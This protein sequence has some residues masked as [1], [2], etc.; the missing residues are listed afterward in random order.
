MDALRSFILRAISPRVCVRDV[1]MVRYASVAV[2]RA[3]A[4][5][6][7]SCVRV[8]SLCHPGQ[9]ADVVRAL[10]GPFDTDEV[11]SCL[12]L[13]HLPMAGA[14]ATRVC[15]H[16]PRYST[17]VTALSLLPCQ[18]GAYATWCGFSTT[19]SMAARS[20]THGPST[21]SSRIR[22]SLSQSA[23]VTRSPWRPNAI[24]VFFR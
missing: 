22:S 20:R 24:L 10:L 18:M 9:V 12:A 1:T 6:D 16:L 23:K 7:L 11:V 2:F 14:V 3:P 17:D 8:A 21:T 13:W 4:P 15:R 19:G 5:I